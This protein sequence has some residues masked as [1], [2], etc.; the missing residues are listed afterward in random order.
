[1]R[2]SI[3]RASTLIVTVLLFIAI[4]GVRAADDTRPVIDDPNFGKDKAAHAS[5]PSV[6]FVG[7]STMKPG[8]VTGANGPMRGWAEEVG[9]YFD[10]A[11][12][13]VVN[14]AIAGRSSRTY[15]NE[16]RWDHVL[17]ELKPG[18]IVVVQFG[19]ND[20]GRYDDPASKFRPSLH[21]EGDDTAD[22]VRPP[23]TGPATQPSAAHETV[24]TFGW[25][26]R[27]YAAD[28]KAKGCT[29]ILCSMVPHK[30]WQDGHTVRGEKETFEQWT[31][32]AATA[33]GAQFINMDDLI[34]TGYDELGQPAVEAFFADRGT[35]TTAAGAKFSAAR[36]IA[37][38]KALKPNPLEAY[39]SKAADTIAPATRP[40][41]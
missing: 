14:R 32:N 29:V 24:H 20:A 27:K 1:M 10:P 33:T 3:F 17:A 8:N 34:A 6:F 2:H 21:G 28:A 36:F 40:G 30:R 23:T 41:N 25:Y 26:M 11:K 37:G 35:H 39:F 38:L 31:G 5:L 22:F 9:V 16:G 15:Q 4:R 12:I 18:D 19:T 7:D 13:N